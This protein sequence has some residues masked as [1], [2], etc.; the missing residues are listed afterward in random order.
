[1][2]MYKSQ[3]VTNTNNPYEPLS[4]RLDKKLAVFSMNFSRC[5]F[6]PTDTEGKKPQRLSLA[7][8]EEP[9]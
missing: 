8:R 4:L 5:M 6:Q 1:M 7:K 3:L 9:S 2:Q